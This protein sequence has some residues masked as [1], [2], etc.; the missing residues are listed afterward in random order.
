MLDE[1]NSRA[2]L[3]EIIHSRNQSGVPGLSK[4]TDIVKSR[5]RFE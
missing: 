3:H 1:N 4:K 2:K 5:A